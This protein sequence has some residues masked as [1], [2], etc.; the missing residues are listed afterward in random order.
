MVFRISKHGSHGGRG[1]FDL[2]QRPGEAM[3]GGGPG[4]TSDPTPL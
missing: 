3:P 1:A 4:A 2:D